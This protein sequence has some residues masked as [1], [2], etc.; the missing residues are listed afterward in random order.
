MKSIIDHLKGFEKEETE[1]IMDYQCAIDC[2][3][4]A[5]DTV[6]RQ[7]LS[8]ILL[9]EQKHLKMLRK[10]LEELKS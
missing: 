9:D 7:V 6:T 5:G 8:D 4:K 2:C 10:R 1:G 3:K